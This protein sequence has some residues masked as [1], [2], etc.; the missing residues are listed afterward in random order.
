MSSSPAASSAA[1][2]ASPQRDVRAAHALDQ[3]QRLALAAAQVVQVAAVDGDVRHGASLQGQRELPLGGARAAGAAGASPS[4][5]DA[6]RTPSSRTGRGGAYS[7][8]SATARS[9]DATGVVRRLGQ[10]PRARHR[11]EV[12]EADLDRD[13]A[14]AAV[15]ALEPLAQLA[16]QPAQRRLHGGALRRGRCR[17]S[18]PATRTPRRAPRRRPRLR[19]R[20]APRR[21]SHGPR[22]APKRALSCSSPAAASA[23]SVVSPIASSRSHRARPDAGQR[24]RATRRRSARTPPRG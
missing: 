17:T 4:A 20:S 14:P 11:R 1:S 6:T 23:P 13:R 5:N 2:N 21:R 12:V 22:R 10:R 18:S 24:A 8:R 15:V 3:Q 9:A 16:R 7:R 19:P